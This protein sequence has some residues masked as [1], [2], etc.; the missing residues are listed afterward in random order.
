VYVGR[1]LE[2]ARRWLPSKRKLGLGS[3]YRS[4]NSLASDPVELRVEL[5]LHWK[6][7]FQFEA[8]NHERSVLF[9]SQF[10]KPIEEGSCF[11]PTVDGTSS[12]IKSCGWS[13]PGPDGIAGGL[14]ARWATHV[15]LDFLQAMLHLAGG[16]LGPGG[17]NVA[18][19]A[20]IP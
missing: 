17:L 16:G 13:A 19:V 9:F 15:T 11:L 5:S 8:S 2:N 4:D 6:K 12:A 1:L 10:V 3:I 20:Y 18:L 7:V 14:W